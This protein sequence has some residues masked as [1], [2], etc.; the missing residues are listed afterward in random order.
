MTFIGSG[1]L[2]AP[3]GGVSQ[4][5]PIRL[6]SVIVGCYVILFGLGTGVWC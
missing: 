6:Q 4:F 3:V 1:T 5:F 2:T